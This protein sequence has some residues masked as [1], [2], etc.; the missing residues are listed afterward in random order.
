[1]WTTTGLSR[2]NS[3]VSLRNWG[4]E[5]VVLKLF[6]AMMAWRLGGASYPGM[7]GR[8]RTV[9]DKSARSASFLSSMLATTVKSS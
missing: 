3:P 6:W 5:Q 9:V 2:L 1:M 8:D 7:T 4:L